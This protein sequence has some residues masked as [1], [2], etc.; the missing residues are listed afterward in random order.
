MGVSYSV[1]V[2]ATAALKPQIEMRLERSLL[3]WADVAKMKADLSKGNGHERNT[4]HLLLSND[5]VE[6]T[7]SNIGMHGMTVNFIRVIIHSGWQ[8]AKKINVCE[9]H[10]ARIYYVRELI[11]QRPE[12]KWLIHHL[13]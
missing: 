5:N 10:F 3:R 7:I 9:T 12:A 13:L 1:V 4:S 8:Q 2:L 11:H 6:R